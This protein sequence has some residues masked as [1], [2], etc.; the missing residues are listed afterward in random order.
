MRIGL[1]YDLRDDYRAMGYSDEDCAEF[2][3]MET[4]DALAAAIG[5]HGV[6]VVRIGHGRNLAEHFVKGER[7]DLVFSIAEGLGGRNREAQVPALC[8][9][10]GQPFA[11]S[12]ALTMSVTLDKGVAKRLVR[13][14][15]IATAPFTV[16][17]NPQQVRRVRLHFP[18]FVKPLHE[19]TGKGCE[20]ASV[21]NNFQE[22]SAAAKTLIGRFGQPVI[23]EKLLTGREFTVGIVGNGKNAHIIAVMEVLVDQAVD[24]GLYSFTNKEQFERYVRYTLPKDEEA[25]LAGERALAAYHALECKDAARVD[26]RSD[27]HGS[28]HFLEVN[29]IAGMHP[30]HSDLPILSTMAGYDYQWLVSEILFSALQRNGL[31]A[32]HSVMPKLRVAVGAL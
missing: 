24:Q 23:V 16:L 22:L 9:L 20:S 26:L 12:D 10:F 7:Y 15:G 13:E 27:A 14:A 21:A 19:G 18:V 4:I 11:F 2:D 1:V 28:P 8:E 3:S 31:S 5:A 29:P 25:M 32:P 17:H 30:T 6:D